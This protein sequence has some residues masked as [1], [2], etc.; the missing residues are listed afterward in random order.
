AAMKGANFIFVGT[1]DQAQDAIRKAAKRTNSVFADSRFVGGMLTNFR[2]RQESIQLMEAMEK[3]QAQGVWEGDSEAVRREKEKRLKKLQ[4]LYKGMQEMDNY[5][6]IA[7]IVDEKKE[8]LARASP[9]FLSSSISLFP[10]SRIPCCS[11]A[12]FIS[13]SL[14]LS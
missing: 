2:C 13:R 9:N 14:S 8:H 4:R 12:S 7:I 11:L 1:K 6:D 5:P 3:Q 10:T